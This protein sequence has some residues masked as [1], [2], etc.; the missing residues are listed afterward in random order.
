MKKGI[1]LTRKTSL[2]DLIK[3]TSI[4]ELVL[5]IQTCERCFTNYNVLGHFKAV[6]ISDH[7][8]HTPLIVV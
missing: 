3:V 7:Y 6:D 8:N 4:S 2:Y 5:G 1:K